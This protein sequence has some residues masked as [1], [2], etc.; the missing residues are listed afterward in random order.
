SWSNPAGLFLLVILLCIPVLLRLL[1]FLL[2]AIVS[3][4]H[5]V[6]L[7]TFSAMGSV[8][9][10]TAPSGC[11]NTRSRPPDPHHGS[12]VE[13]AGAVLVARGASILHP[14]PVMNDRGNDFS[15]AYDAMTLRTPVPHST[16]T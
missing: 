6:L 10:G 14:T 13:S 1:G 11:A 4:G 7:D 3:L 15:M 2:L 16:T 8:G 5:D 9:S 12:H